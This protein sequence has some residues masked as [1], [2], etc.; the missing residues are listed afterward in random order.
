MDVKDPASYAKAYSKV[1][2]AQEDSGNMDGGYGLRAQVA[3]RIHTI[4][5]MLLLG[6]V[7]LSQQWKVNNNCI[8]VMNLQ[9]FLKLFQ[10]IEN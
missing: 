5:I 2:K 8:Q 10:V 9:S 6:L 4:H 3:G 1:V 7:A